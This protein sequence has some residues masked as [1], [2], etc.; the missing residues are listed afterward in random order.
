MKYLSILVAV[1]LICTGC[2]T[3]TET[4][5][6]ADGTVVT[7][8]S[9]DVNWDQISDATT[10]YFELRRLEYE[11]SRLE[12]E[13]EREQDE[14]EQERIREYIDQITIAITQLCGIV[15]GKRSSK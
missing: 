10:L 2:A 15:T 3:T 11:Q 12:Y 1:G 8:E 4:L 13:L 7:T 14:A 5:T 6:L 9:Y